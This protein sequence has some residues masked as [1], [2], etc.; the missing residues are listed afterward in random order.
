ML[1]F[2]AVVALFGAYMIGSALHMK[3][4]GR[5]NSMVLAQEEL[6]KVKDTKGFIEFLYWREMLFGALVLIVGVL[7]VQVALNQPFPFAVPVVDFHQEVQMHQVVRIENHHGIVLL[8]QGK[9]LL[10]HPFQG[11]ALALLHFV[12]VVPFV[13]QGAL[14]SCHFRRMVAA[15]ISYHENIVHIIG[16]TQHL[17]VI[18][19]LANYLFLV[20]G[21]HN[22]RKSGFGGQDLLFLFPGQNAEQGNG[23]VVNRKENDQHLQRNHNNIKIAAHD[24][25]RLPPLNGR[26]ACQS[27]LHTEHRV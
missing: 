4:S 25:H 2:D 8:G 10:E 3:K 5:I 19:Q 14:T 17:Q 12:G 7:G 27:P 16:I 6:K 13:H 24:E 21:S 26:L 20:M 23:K 18:H 22:H 11:K 1:V 15:I 9:Q